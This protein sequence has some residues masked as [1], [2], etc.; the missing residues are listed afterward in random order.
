MSL[1]QTFYEALFDPEI[2]SPEGLCCWHSADPASR[3]SVYRNNRVVSLIDTLANTL[4]VTQL[5]VGEEFFRAMAYLFVN[6]TPPHSPILAD[7][8]QLFSEFI[9]RFPPAAPT[10]YLADIARLERLR[11]VAYHAAD[12]LPASIDELTNMLLNPEELPVLQLNLHPSTKLISSPYAIVSL[13]AAHQNNIDINLSTIDPYQP[14]QA[15]IVRPYLDVNVIPLSRETFSFINYLLKGENLG[16]AMTLVI[17]E[18][19]DFNLTATLSLLIQQG[20]ISSSEPNG[21]NI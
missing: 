12:Q 10:P 14:E 5:L 4:P 7:Y 1:L 3:F 9:E 15:V 8:G 2:A 20:L 17:N 18:W 6:T 13:W 21:N 11:V 16:N 19:P